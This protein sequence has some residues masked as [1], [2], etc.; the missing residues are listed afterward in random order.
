M[1]TDF[2]D[3]NE[4]FCPEVVHKYSEFA[5]NFLDVRLAI[6]IESIRMRLNKAIYVN[7]YSVHG[8]LTQRGFRCVKCQLMTDVYK[9]GELFT[10]PHS[11]GKGIDFDVAGLVASEVREYII[12]NRNL[13][14][15]P[16]RLENNVSWVHLDILNSNYNDKV[17]FFEK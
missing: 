7:D 3:L 12:K 17:I 15:Y 9:S 14:P 8:K 2:F 13:W 1:I 6:T 10:D 16:L 4:V 5:W 11:L